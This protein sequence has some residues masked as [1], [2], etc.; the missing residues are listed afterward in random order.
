MFFWQRVVVQTTGFIGYIIIQHHNVILFFSLDMFRLLSY[1][2]STLNC[3]SVLVLLLQKVVS[4]TAL[5]V[6]WS[7]SASIKGFCAVIH[8]VKHFEISNRKWYVNL[9]KVE[10]T[11]K[12]TFWKTKNK[13]LIMTLSLIYIHKIL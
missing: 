6:S 7:C 2:W 12:K 3:F 4:Y 13:S 11:K 8:F 1:P 9:R 10:K 5:Q